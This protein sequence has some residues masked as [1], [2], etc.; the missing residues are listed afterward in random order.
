[1]RLGDSSRQMWLGWSREQRQEKAGIRGVRRGRGEEWGHKG[2][3]KWEQKPKENHNHMPSGYP[4][5]ELSVQ[6]LGSVPSLNGKR[7]ILF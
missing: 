6:S 3:S 1:M 7:I 4:A 2:S 5:S